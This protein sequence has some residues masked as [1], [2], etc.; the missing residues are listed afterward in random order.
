MSKAIPG[1]S[2]S[3][4][5]PDADLLATIQ[6]HDELWAEWDRRVPVDQDDPKISELSDECY[7][8]ECGIFLARPQTPE[9]LA[10]KTRIISKVEFY[11]YG[12][13]EIVAMTLEADAER[14]AAR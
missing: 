1:S 6:Q 13:E 3:K 11:L 8:L 5:N 2:T 7:E 14:I 12:A 9:G 4:Q 10:D